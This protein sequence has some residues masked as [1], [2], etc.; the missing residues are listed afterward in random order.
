VTTSVIIAFTAPVLPLDDEV[1]LAAVASDRAP[2]Q[3]G[4]AVKLDGLFET[5]R[6]YVY[7]EGWRRAPRVVRS[8]EQIGHRL[9]NRKLTVLTLTAG[10]LRVALVGWDDRYAGDVARWLRTCTALDVTIRRTGTIRSLS[11]TTAWAEQLDADL[12]LIETPDWR[13]APFVNAG[14]VLLPKRVGHLERLDREEST[15][16]QRVRR[17]LERLPI[18]VVWSRSAHDLE[19]FYFAHYLPMVERRH[20]VHGRPTPL[21]VLRA[22]MKDGWL[23]KVGD[24]RRWASGALVAPH[25]L[26]ASCLSIAVLGIRGG[27]YADVAEPLRIA[28]VLLAR[29]FARSLGLRFCDHLVTRPFC[30]DGLFRRKRRWSTELYDLG[31]RADRVLMRARRDTPALR[32]VLGSGFIALHEGRLEALA[33]APV[34]KPASGDLVKLPL[35][36]W[37]PFPS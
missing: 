33:W 11:V 37:E 27:D 19:E 29:D 30:S 13:A 7:R 32:R 34:S 9:R 21:P 12:Q 18:N 24:G 35:R 2:R 4:R 3:D 16:A 26:I 22:I 36:S 1:G 31:E 14:F 8:V 10:E 17:K 23:L 5:A 20:G 28:P 25:P 15:H 6:F